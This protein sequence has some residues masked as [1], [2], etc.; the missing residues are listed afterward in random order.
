MFMGDVRGSVARRSP[1]AAA[2]SRDVSQRVARQQLRAQVTREQFERHP[3]EE[4]V[5]HSCE[6]LEK[7]LVKS[8]R[9]IPAKRLRGH[10][11]VLVT[12]HQCH[13]WCPGR[14]CKGLRVKR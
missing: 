6:E 9:S 7:H 11:S 5:K 10:V 13:Y 14:L 4:L 3:C 2:C 8:L 1:G 12:S